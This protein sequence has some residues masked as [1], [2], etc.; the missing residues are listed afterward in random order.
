[1]FPIPLSIVLFLIEITEGF[2]RA[3]GK[4]RNLE[5]PNPEG[6]EIEEKILPGRMDMKEFVKKYA[7][8]MLKAAG[9]A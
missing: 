9:D 1:M 3:K 2:Y 8:V 5:A 6:E 7:E 4:M